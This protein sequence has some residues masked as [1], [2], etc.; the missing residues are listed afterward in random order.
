MSDTEDDY[1]LT[2]RVARKMTA[3]QKVGAQKFT[4]ATKAYKHLE[5]LFKDKS[6]QPTDKPSD[7]RMKDPLFQ[8]FTNQQFRSQFNK[9]KSMHGTCSKEG[10]FI[11][12]TLTMSKLLCTNSTLVNRLSATREG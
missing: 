2:G 10:M 1:L 12:Q 11:L 6:I 7:V 9:L 8:D 4:Q 5:K 3:P